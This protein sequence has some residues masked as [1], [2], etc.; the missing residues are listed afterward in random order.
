MSS[1][2]HLAIE[3]SG[4]VGSFALGTDDA[5][6]DAVELPPQT[7]GAGSGG[8]SELLFHLDAL[9]G[10]HAIAPAQISEVY[11]SIGPGSFTGLRIGVTIA[12]LLARAIGARI[13][14][15]PTLD[16]VARNAPAGVRHVAVCLN[17]KKE[18]VYAGVFTRQEAGWRAY[19]EPSLRSMRELLAAAPRPLAIIGDPL[20]A[21]DAAAEVAVLP[22]TLARGRAEVVWEL[23]RL[24]ARAGLFTDPLEL[25]PLYVRPPEAVELWDKRHGKSA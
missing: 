5:I 1:S 11:L 23:G 7:G 14:A 3:T 8:S 6:L 13:V 9:C 19:D 4:R 22:A 17:L 2:F 12:K 16:V 21:M 20:P 10:K 15:V 18:T 25:L 24:A